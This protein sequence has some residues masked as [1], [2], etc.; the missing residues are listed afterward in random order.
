MAA[1][2]DLRALERLEKNANLIFCLF[3][4]SFLKIK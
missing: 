1:I 4:V 3:L 2:L